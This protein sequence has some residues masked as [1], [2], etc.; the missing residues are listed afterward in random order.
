MRWLVTAVVVAGTI[1]WT[2]PDVLIGLVGAFVGML[3]AMTAPQ[4]GLAFG[5]VLFGLRITHLIIGL[6]S[7]VKA[8]TWTNRRVVVRA[9]PLLATVGITGQKPGVRWRTV[10]TGAFAVL[11]Y[12]GVVALMWLATGSAFGRG[13]A[14]AGAGC[15]ALQLVPV[16]QAG[17]TS[18]GWFVFTLPKLSGRPLAE[19]EAR[20]RVLAGMDAYQRGDLDEAERVVDGLLRDHPDLITVVGLK[21][22]TACARERYLDALQSV[23]GLSAR[24]DLG[25]HE[26]SLVMATTAGVTALAVEAGQFPAEVGL[27]T[28]RDML[29]NAYEAGYPRHRANGTLA[30]IALL[31][32]DTAEA[33][34]LAR[35]AADSSENAA[36]RADELVTIARAW[37]ADGDNA[38]ARELAAE[39]HQLAGWS[40]RVAA[41]HA[42]LQ[43]S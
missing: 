9:V 17:H 14:L 10:S 6:G 24:E 3:V 28:A 16:K 18:L 41:T 7:E 43:I 42:R 1:A 25:A 34:R 27:E 39:A 23:V 40:P 37:M 32:G 31:E 29:G 33:R 4:A 36:E 38:K 35:H 11:F 13:M 2:Y 5:A 26:L 22:V 15:L 12:A 30:I 21:V 20:P 19:L 8:W